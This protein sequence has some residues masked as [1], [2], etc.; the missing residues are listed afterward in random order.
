MSHALEQD[1]RVE[2]DSGDIPTKQMPS[3]RVTQIQVAPRSKK[4]R[5]NI[6]K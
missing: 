2:G 5:I 6:E 3:S 1:S 4:E